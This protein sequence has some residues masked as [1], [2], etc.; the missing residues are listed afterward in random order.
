M[1]FILILAPPNSLIP[2]RMN[3]QPTPVFL[4]GQSRGQRSLEA[5]SPWGL[6]ELDTTERLSNS[7]LIYLLMQVI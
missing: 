4:P 6:K 1:Y 3:W 5:Y 7:S 2:W